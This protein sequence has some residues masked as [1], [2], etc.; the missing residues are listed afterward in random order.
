MRKT[1]KPSST[2]DKLIEEIKAY[3]KEL[4]VTQTE[5][6]K[7]C[8]I[9]QSEISRLESKKVTAN[10]QLLIEVAEALGLELSLVKKQG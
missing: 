7:R 3:R 6:A 1:E 4:E 9:P 2:Y 5:L 8:Q 10:A